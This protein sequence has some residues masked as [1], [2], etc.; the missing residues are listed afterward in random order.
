[1]VKK[2][3][4]SVL[5][6]SAFCSDRGLNKKGMVVWGTKSHSGRVYGDVVDIWRNYAE[7]V[8]GGPISCGHYVQEEAP[9][10]TL[11]RLR[12]FFGEKSAA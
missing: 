1:M 5:E 9:R 11:A 12:D 4:G 3:H 6:N 8:Q 2:E 10:E 7:D